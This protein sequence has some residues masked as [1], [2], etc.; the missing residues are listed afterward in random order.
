[1]GGGCVAT[2]TM[3]GDGGR[4][5]AAAAV[6]VAQNQRRIMRQNPLGKPSTLR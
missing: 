5:A 1:M 6:T 3:R 4:R 2:V